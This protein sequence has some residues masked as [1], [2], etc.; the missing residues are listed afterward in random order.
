VT[1]LQ[2]VSNPEKFKWGFSSVACTVKAWGPASRVLE[3]TE[4]LTAGIKPP[5]SRIYH[6]LPFSPVA[7]N[8]HFP[9]VF[10]AYTITHLFLTIILI[11]VQTVRV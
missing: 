2:A 4:D 7:K 3:C 5:N 11:K 6:S 10:T 9:Y 8:L 1:R